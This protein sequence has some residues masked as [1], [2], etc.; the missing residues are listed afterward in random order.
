MTGNDQEG[1]ARTPEIVK[2]YSPNRGGK[3]ALPRSAFATYVAMGEDRSYRAV[4][5]RYGV[6]VGTVQ[7]HAS[8]E[9]WRSSLAYIHDRAQESAV[10]A[11]RETYEAMV[12]RHVRALNIVQSAALEA[13][14]KTRPDSWESASGA[15]MR[16]QRMERDART[17]AEGADQGPSRMIEQEARWATS[18]PATEVAPT[19][20]AGAT[21]EA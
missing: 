19:S 20:S 1:P 13:M 11:V 3:R 18:S 12:V 6:S 9:G 14:A 5:E 7:R 21:P 10:E 8:A 17:V 15:L 16:S 4:A 2:R